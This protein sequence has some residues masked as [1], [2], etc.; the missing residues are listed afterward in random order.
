MS[1]YTT[2]LR[3]ICEQY[4]GYDES[5]DLSSVKDIIAKSLPKVFDFDF[6]IY[7][8]KYRSVLETK[9]IKHFYT[10][11]IG[12]ETVGRWKLA[13][14]ERLNLIMPYYNQRYKS[15]LI[16]FNPMYDI[17]ITTDHNKGNEGN[18]E[19]NTDSTNNRTYSR[20]ED[21]KRNLASNNSTEN[22][23][24]SWNMYNDTPQ[25]ALTG[26]RDEK[27]LT[28][29]THN[30]ATESNTNT[31]TDTGTTNT[32]TNDKDDTTSKASGTSK[33]TDTES[34][35]EH[36]RGKTA[37]TSYSKMLSEYRKTF[38]NIDNEIINE[39]NDLFINLW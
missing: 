5:K 9:I 37:G 12:Y 33:Y 27:Y 17:D 25:G 20:T 21:Y 19:S 29:A 26:I 18:S 32:N 7:D 3:Y 16:E 11:E 34:Y 4:S 36:V 22:N 23:N 8:E 14:D 10:R 24:D 31:S 39:L 2:E 13:L 6:P 1:K 30:A 35:L 28:N 15:A 38:I